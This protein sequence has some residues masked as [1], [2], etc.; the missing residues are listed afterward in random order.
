VAGFYSLAS[1]HVELNQRDRRR[2]NVEPVRVPATLV[3]WIAKERRAVID[4]N[5]LL[6]HAAA[7]ARQAAAL[8]ATA[9]LVVD[10]FD[11]ETAAM[12]RERYGFRP[13]AEAKKP[14]RL[15]IALQV[16]D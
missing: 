8:Q 4:G 1:A 10:P 16:D 14:T 2:A 5:L 15:W 3:S 7:T 12:W 6:L 11:Q 9:V 13:S